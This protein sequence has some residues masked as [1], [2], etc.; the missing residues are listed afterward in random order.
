MR[1]ASLGSTHAGWYNWH[2]LHAG[3]LR[4]Q[5]CMVRQL[6]EG[7][8]TA[9]TPDVTRTD[10]Y[11]MAHYA[12]RAMMDYSSRPSAGHTLRRVNTSRV[13]A[14][15]SP[16]ASSF[17]LAH[18]PSAPIS[19]P[20]APSLLPTVSS[21]LGDQAAAALAGGQSLEMQPAVPDAGVLTPVVT[22][23]L[24][25]AVAANFLF[26]N[27]SDK[28]RLA[29]FGAMQHVQVQAGQ[30]VIRQGDPGDHFYVVDQ[31]LFDVYLQQSPLS[32]PE[33]VHTYGHVPTSVAEGE[34]ASEHDHGPH[35][36]FG[37]LALL[38]SKPRAATVVARTEGSLWSLHRN[39]Y[40]A[41]LQV[42]CFPADDGRGLNVLGALQSHCCALTLDR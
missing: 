33:L 22:D 30:L 21:I 23:M 42:G 12:H 35:A 31:G 1:T 16:S 18:Q 20:M 5:L 11:S 25:E 34:T 32:P 29:V 39:D 2:G 10:T 37:E 15:E 24:E 38:Y 13:A 40:K 4:H 6:H 27:M 9:P 26:G 28:E 8:H 36:S 19:L 41:A 3:G 7:C 17:S 14:I